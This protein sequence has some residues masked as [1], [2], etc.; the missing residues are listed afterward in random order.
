MNHKILQELQ[1]LSP[2]LARLKKHHQ[3][4]DM[5][6]GYQEQL[7]QK[8]KSD[9]PR[10]VKTKTFNLSILGAV[11]A[12]CL[13]LIAYLSL[14]NP[15]SQVDIQDEVYENYVLENLDEFEDILVIDQGADSWLTKKLDDIPETELITYLE[16]NLDHLD[17]DIQY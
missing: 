2:E 13:V 10:E 11:A 9:L 3:Q 4:V 17:L 6:I 12:S 14:I 1:E 8:I 5:P 16:N 7:F 15:T